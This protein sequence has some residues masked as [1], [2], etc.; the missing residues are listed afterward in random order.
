MKYFDKKKKANPGPESTLPGVAPVMP[1]FPTIKE[2]LEAAIK[3]TG[4]KS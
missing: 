4:Y 2:A 1:E 3:T